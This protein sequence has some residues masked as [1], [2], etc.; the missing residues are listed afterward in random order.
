[1]KYLKQLV[2]VS[3][4]A[5][6]VLGCA[7]KQVVE[8]KPYNSKYNQE[9]SSKTI[10]LIKINDKRENKIVA[11]IEKEGQIIKQFKARN[12]LENW[13]TDALRKDFS[14]AGIDNSAEANTRL[15]INIL[16]LNAKYTHKKTASSNLYGNVEVQLVFTTGNTVKTKQIK[17]SFN[18]WKISMDDASDF[19][20]FLQE[21]LSDSVLNSLNAIIKTL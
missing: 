3:I 19:E 12:N 16:N 8:L 18:K 21:S 13:F 2:L 1:M 10:N 9:A 4:T 14:T 17:N 11:V 5:L 6:V 15:V 20:D 7:N